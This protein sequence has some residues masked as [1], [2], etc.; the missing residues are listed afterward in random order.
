MALIPLFRR[1]PGLRHEV[2]AEEL[3]RHA[4]GPNVHAADTLPVTW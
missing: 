2:P 4:F 3:S 1:F